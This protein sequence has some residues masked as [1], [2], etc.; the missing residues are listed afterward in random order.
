MNDPID[1]LVHIVTSL[2]MTDADTARARLSAP[3]SAAAPDVAVATLT[4]LVRQAPTTHGERTRLLTLLASVADAVSTVRMLGAADLLRRLPPRFPEPATLI[5]LPALDP[6]LTETFTVLQSLDKIAHPW[7]VVG[8]LMVMAHCVEHGVPFARATGDADIA[9]GVFTH[10]RALRDLTRHLASIG[11]TDITPAP[12]AGPPLSYRWSR[13]PVIIDLLV[14]ERV[15][16]QLS[17]PMTASRLPAVEL[18]GVQQALARSERVTLRLDGGRE[19]PFIRPDLL[20]ALTIK[21]AAAVADRRDPDRHLGDLVSLA[22]S[23]AASGEVVRFTR[24]IRPEDRGRITRGVA[25]LTPAHWRRAADSVAA[26]DAI[27]LLLG[28]EP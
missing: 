8:G 22:D 19:G 5:A 26:H 3:R 20:G 7:T 13:S 12:L 15:N 24:E 27:D 1:P 9:V 4:N 21:S 14:P 28:R 17:V 6:V 25:L 10:R 23:L 2:T 11:F 18:P 16:D